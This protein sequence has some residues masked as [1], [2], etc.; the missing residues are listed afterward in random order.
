MYLTQAV[1]YVA[2]TFSCL[3]RIQNQL[4]SQ[5]LVKDRLAKQSSFTCRTSDIGEVRCLK[6]DFFTIVDYSL[7]AKQQDHTSPIIVE[8]GGFGWSLER[9][10]ILKDINFV[11]QRASLTVVTGPVGCGKSTL[12]RGLLGETPDTRG[13]IIRTS[14]RIA[15]CDESPWLSNSTIRQNITNFHKFDQSW[16]HTTVTACALLKDLESFPEG[17]RTLAGSQGIRLSGGQKQRIV[18]HISYIQG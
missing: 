15:F 9:P 12:L 18:S 13:L 4:H 3:N 11:C 17:D 10:L 16:Y 1:P 5:T 2:S 6:E 7:D 8:N 14:S